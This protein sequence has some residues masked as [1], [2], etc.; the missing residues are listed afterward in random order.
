MAFK[1]GSA[2]ANPRTRPG[3][4]T[5]WLALRLDRGEFNPFWALAIRRMRRREP[6]SE[7]VLW[8]LLLLSWGCA[9]L[10]ISIETILWLMMLMPG[11]IALHYGSLLSIAV[12]DM[13]RTRQ[14]SELIIAP[15]SGQNLLRAEWRS[16]AFAFQ[17]GLIALLLLLPPIVLSHWLFAGES[18]VLE[19][20]GV[21]GLFSGSMVFLLPACLASRV[22]VLR[23]GVSP[24]ALVVLALLCPMGVL[25]VFPLVLWLVFMG[26]FKRGDPEGFLLWLAREDDPGVLPRAGIALRWWCA[27]PGRCWR[28]VFCRRRSPADA[29]AA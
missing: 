24:V 9:L 17:M 22:S 29:A 11:V 10:S 20:L 2:F 27:V 6:Y 21:L 28:M 1:G 15:G 13:I 4:L 19:M 5:G 16:M 18:F 8:M 14:L 7:F 12:K 23:D 25:V 3:G 26:G